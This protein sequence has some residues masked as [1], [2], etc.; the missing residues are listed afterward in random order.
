MYRYGM[1]AVGPE[2][3]SLRVFTLIPNYDIYVTPTFTERRYSGGIGTSV[4]AGICRH[5]VSA[6]RST[7]IPALINVHIE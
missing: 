3:V 5:I 2:P 4:L 1:T 7:Q 6:E